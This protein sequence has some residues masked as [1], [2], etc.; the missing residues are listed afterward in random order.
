MDNKIKISVRSLVEYVY[1]SGSIETGF[2]SAVPLSEGTRIHQRIQKLYGEEDQ[3]EVYL[4]TVLTFN[5]LDFQL[6]GRCDGLFIRNEEHII[7]EIK[8][9][10]LPLS[11]ID[12]FAYPVHW[13][14]AKCYAFMY[15]KDHNLP[16]MTVQLT[17]V[18][19]KTDEVKRFQQSYSLRELEEFI[20]YLL[21]SYF[22]YADWKIQHQQALTKSI[23]ELAFP[24]PAYRNGQRRFAGA[25]YKTIA[26]GKNLF[27]NAPTGIGKTISTLFP[28][29]KA[30]G[31][32]H[33][34]RI[35]Y[36][37]AK[38]ITRQ[39]AEGAI[40]MMGDDGLNLKSVTIT[41]KDKICFKE[42]TNCQKDSCEFANGYY[43]RINQAV[44]DLLKNENMIS[45]T[46]IEQYAK[47]HKVCPFEF[48]LDAAY[49]ADAIIGD[50][51][52]I[53]DPRVSLKRLLEEEKKKTALLI[54]E[55]HNL[56][57]RGREMYSSS[58]EKSAFLQ[59]SRSFKGKDEGIQ[60]SAKQVNGIFI[61]LKKKCGENQEIAE[62]NPPEEL[63]EILEEFVQ[64]AENY[65]GQN[66]NNTEE[67]LLEV[68]FAAQNFIRIG[69]L[70][71]DRFVTYIQKER[72]DLIIKLFCLDPSSLLHKA[73]KGYKSAIFFSATL[74]PL[75]YYLD[76][77]GFQEEDFIV[78]VPSPFSKDQAKVYIQPLST[79]YRDREG[80]IEP[81]VR[82]IK[83]MLKGQ[84]G[85]YLIFFP[86]YQY[87]E[88]VYGRFL[89][90]E[91]PVHAI[92][93]KTGMD[94]REREEFLDAFQP[95]A[96]GTLLGFAVMGGIFSE[97]I[98]LQGDRLNGVFVVGVGLPQI[99]FER[100]MMKA[101]FQQQGKNGY[102]YAYTYP[103]MNKVLQAGGRLIRSENDTGMIVLMDDRY[104]QANYQTLL[105]DE[106]KDSILLRS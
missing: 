15:A 99:G 89:D 70:Y 68:F 86:S 41:A 72:N 95:N 29:L 64:Y 104:L 9:V 17:Y 13:A 69:K 11:E 18:Q 24:F 103:G 62:K 61:A 57:D 27:A 98:D 105:P 31:E 84:K 51:N 39:A 32:G 60:K 4:H 44:L 102:D 83:S 73:R 35:I 2:R 8:S 47:K 43:D 81:I 76:M 33:I 82:T 38:T 56:V 3:K 55:A 23:Q 12:E 21:E 66:R 87:M 106:W 34:Q 16:D 91:M 49:A 10:S 85:N 67:E 65:L 7:D 63:F 37:T 26:E 14:Q 77:L 92:I 6:E 88:I 52:Y 50:Y 45:R 90:E 5:H 42:E 97:G 40:A 20:L 53:F 79:R 36:A 46:A 28:A 54:D 30:I 101:Y 22:P 96:S 75:N 1:K 59:L 74:M 100:D 78:S 71:D 80:S 94:E 48:S 19:S 25:V 93:Q 58:L